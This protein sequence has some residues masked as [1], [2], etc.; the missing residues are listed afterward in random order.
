MECTTKHVDR[1]TGE[2]IDKPK[3]KFKNLESAIKHAKSVNS[4]PDRKYKVVSYKCHICYGF[5]VGRN[6]KEL[7]TKDK[8]KYK[9]ALNRGFK[10]IGKID[11]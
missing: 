10:I 1:I 2:L 6:G 4:L 11:L 3:I 5:H 8:D 7:S 9:K